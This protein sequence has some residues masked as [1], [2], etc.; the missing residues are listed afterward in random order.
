MTNPSETPI[1]NDSQKRHVQ[2]QIHT[3]GTHLT[4]QL[5]DVVK[6]TNSCIV[7]KQIIRNVASENGVRLSNSS[8]ETRTTNSA[9]LIRS[10][11]EPSNE[12]ITELPEPKRSV[13]RVNTA[14]SIV[15]KFRLHPERF[16]SP[17]NRYL[18]LLR[19]QALE[20]ESRESSSKQQ[21]DKSDST[22]NQRRHFSP[23]MS[24]L[25]DGSDLTYDDAKSFLSE[26]VDLGLVQ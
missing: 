2:F 12:Q 20:L 25:S 21:K 4:S 19:R 1:D 23:P 15:A 18:P 3:E 9:P 6:K 16:L 26:E 11:V 10:I 24:R 5:A 8:R 13:Y 22:K 7:D 14:K 17:S